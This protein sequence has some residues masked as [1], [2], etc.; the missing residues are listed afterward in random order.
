[1]ADVGNA[2]WIIT[3]IENIIANIDNAKESDY[4]KLENEIRKG[5][6]PILQKLN[7]YSG[8]EKKGTRYFT[9]TL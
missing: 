1:M 6:H 4:Q 7:I 2:A 8:K 9:R 5:I 3:K